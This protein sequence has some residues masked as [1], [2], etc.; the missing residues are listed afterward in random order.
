M[1]FRNNILIL[2]KGKIG[3][4]YHI[5]TNSFFSIKSVVKKISILKKLDL[6]NF[7]EMRKIGWARITVTD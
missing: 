2:T 5:S 3:S 4:T 7:S 1:M 6:K